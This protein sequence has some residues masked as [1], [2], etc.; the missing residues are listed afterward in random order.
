MNRTGHLTREFLA[1]LVVLLRRVAIPCESILETVDI[2]EEQTPHC[3][4]ER[5]IA[6]PCHINGTH[7]D[8]GTEIPCRIIVA[9]AKR[10]AGRCRRCGCQRKAVVIDPFSKAVT[11]F[12]DGICAYR[13]TGIYHLGAAQ[14][15]CEIQKQ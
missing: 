7:T 9:E 8:R 14:S 13:D 10:I 12:V 3:K 2:L 5:R 11:C 6:D 1:K 15:F 4:E